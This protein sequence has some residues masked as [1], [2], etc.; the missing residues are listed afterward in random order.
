MLSGARET[1]RGGHR[2]RARRVVLAL[3][4]YAHL[5]LALGVLSRPELAALPNPSHGGTDGPDDGF[6][7]QAA[8]Q[9]R[10]LIVSVLASYVSWTSFSARRCR[11]ARRHGP[12]RPSSGVRTATA[13]HPASLWLTSLTVQGCLLLVW[14]LGRVYPTCCHST[15]MILVPY[16]LIGLP[17]QAGLQWQGGQGRGLM[18]VVALVSSG[19]GFWRL[20]RVEYLLLSLLLYGPGLLLFL[21]SRRQLGAF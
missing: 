14:L 1:T 19:Y 4:L 7:G 3:L 13:P 12:S 17:A 2:H 10:P 16:L 9:R 21:C 18:R 8:H 15:S 20:R 5:V 11:S 6:L